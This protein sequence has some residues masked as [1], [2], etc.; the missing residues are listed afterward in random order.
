MIF[1]KSLFIWRIFILFL[2]HAFVWNYHIAYL[3]YGCNYVFNKL[4]N[5]TIDKKEEKKKHVM[6]R[7]SKS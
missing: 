1:E 6:G 4:L 3:E 7:L 5:G 2:H